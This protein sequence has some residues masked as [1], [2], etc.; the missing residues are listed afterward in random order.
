MI[1]FEQKPRLQ[2]HRLPGGFCYLFIVYNQ[3]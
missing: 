1:Q 2:G 3:S